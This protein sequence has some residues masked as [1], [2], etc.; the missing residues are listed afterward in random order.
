MA[1]VQARATAHVAAV[2]AE[3]PG[4]RIAVVSHADVLR[5]IVAHVLGLPLDR[6]L[7]FDI[8]PGSISTLA[9]G[10]WGARV[11]ALNQPA[12]SPG[13]A[14]SERRDAA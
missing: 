12:V 9:V 3:H 6:M 14:V 7:G 2:A 13:P 5:G 4:G 8:D 10:D 1:A 11:I